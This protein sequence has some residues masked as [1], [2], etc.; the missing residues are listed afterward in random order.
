[1]ANNTGHDRTGIKTW[2]WKQARECLVDPCFWFAGINAFLSSVPN[3][4]LTTFNAILNTGFGFS[5]LQFILLDIPRS[6]IS[7]VYFVV[8]GLVCSKWKNLRM[9]FMMFS[10]IPPFIGF[11]ILSLLPNEPQYKW[12]KWGGYV[13]TVTSVIALF[14]AWTLIPSNI[15]GRT[16]RTLTSSFT[17]VGYCVGNI[18][19]SQIFN[20]KDAVSKPSFRV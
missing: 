9:Y 19:G 16:K 10:V 5:N 11:I 12:V 14:L 17:F 13:M 20:Y 4:G 8:I 18:V 7:V 2:K 1:M 3:G 15:A 6:L